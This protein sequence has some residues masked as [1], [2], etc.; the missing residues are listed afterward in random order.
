MTKLQLSFAIGNYD[1]TRA[2]I[3]SAVTIDGVDPVYMTLVPEEIFF[4]AFRAAEIRYLRALTIELYD[5]DRARREPLHSDTRLRFAGVPPH[6]YLR[7]HRPR[8]K[9]ADLKGK[10]VGVPEYQLTAN[11]WARAFLSDDYGSGGI[12]ARIGLRMMPTFPRSS[13]SFRTAGFPQYGWK[14]GI[15]GGTFPKRQSA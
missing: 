14:A 9:P 13:L 4:R 12:E 7:S 1:R 8:K 15:S 3:G 10:K 6:G 2:L 5:S 11:V